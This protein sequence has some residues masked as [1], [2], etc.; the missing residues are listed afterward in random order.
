MMMKYVYLSGYA[1]IFLSMT[2]L[3]VEEF[4]RLVDDIRP[5][6]VGAEVERLSRPDR[7]Q[8]MGGGVAPA[9][10]LRD[11]VLL[12]VINL[13]QYPTQDVLGYFFGVSQASVSRILQ[14]ILPLLAA[15]GPDRMRRSDPG[16]QRP[17]RLGAMPA[18][19][20]AL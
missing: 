8:A 10:S 7:Q 1:Q 9:L 14:R 5:L 13:R 15:D 11:Q 19:V 2:G 3:R 17:R 4:D 12:S 6:F 18:T 16:R 20:A